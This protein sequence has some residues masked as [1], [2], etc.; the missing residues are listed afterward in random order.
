MGHGHLICCQW[1]RVLAKAMNRNTRHSASSLGFKSLPPLYIC[2]FPALTEVEQDILMG[3]VGGGVT[4]LLLNHLFFC[5][6]RNL[7]KA[8]ASTRCYIAPHQDY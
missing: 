7:L 1:S 4:S 3:V 5:P 6:L 8:M 2:S